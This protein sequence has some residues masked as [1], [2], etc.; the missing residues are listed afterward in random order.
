[1]LAFEAPEDVAS[2]ASQDMQIW[3]KARPTDV[4]VVLSAQFKQKSENG[5]AST[6]MSAAIRPTSRMLGVANAA[7]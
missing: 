2:A 5:W 7:S 4:P 1:M 6:K 3:S